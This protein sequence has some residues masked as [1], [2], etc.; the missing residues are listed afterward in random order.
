MQISGSRSKYNVFE[1]TPLVGPFK[2]VHLFCPIIFSA[3][4]GS[5]VQRVGA[6]RPD[7]CER[8]GLVHRVPHPGHPLHGDDG[9]LLRLLHCPLL[10]ARLPAPRPR[11]QSAQV[12]GHRGC[13]EVEIII[14]MLK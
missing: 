1:S 3:L 11:Q 2:I 4:L 12:F 6:V 7:L 8:L 14:I 10:P 5:D 9:L 13:R